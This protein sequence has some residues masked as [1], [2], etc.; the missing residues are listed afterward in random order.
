[1][2]LMRA[3]RSP[4][5]VILLVLASV[6]GCKDGKTTSA[7]VETADFMEKLASQVRGPRVVIEPR[8]VTEPRIVI[9]EEFVLPAGGWKSS[10]FMLANVRP[11]RLSVE[12]VKDA[13]KGFT[14]YVIRTYEEDLF[15]RK[16]IF[17][18]IPSFYGSKTTSFSHTEELIQG[19]WTV[20]VQNTESPLR[21]M[22]VHVQLTTDPK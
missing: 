10:S 5:L 20:I 4:H 18:Y 9:N 11:V 22:T 8:G 2:H 12:G 17:H 15:R 16:G 19:D 7:A 13:A 3:L 14:V 1:M 6:S 21:P